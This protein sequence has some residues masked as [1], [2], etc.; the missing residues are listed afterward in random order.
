MPDLAQLGPT[1]GCVAIA[2]LLIRFMKDENHRRD[3]R[4]HEL[5]NSIRENSKVTQEVS[6]YL[7]QR[8]GSG[9]RLIKELGEKLDKHAL[10]ENRLVTKTAEL[11]EDSK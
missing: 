9:D 6:T 4:D 3:T 8:N 7:K 1:A 5:S 2:Y 11:K 10:I